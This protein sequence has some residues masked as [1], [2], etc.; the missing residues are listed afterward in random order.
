MKKQ[1]I[2]TAVL[3]F[4]CAMAL[5]LD[6]GDYCMAAV[7]VPQVTGVTAVR[8]DVNSVRV[9]WD[10]VDGAKGYVLY[11]K[12]GSG[13]FQAVK[14]FKKNSCTLR[15]MSV[16]TT[17]CFKVKA[18]AKAGRKTYYGKTSVVRKYTVNDYEYMLDLM[19]PYAHYY[20]YDEYN[21]PTS[22]LHMGG[23]EYR[24]SFKLGSYWNSDIY[25]NAF[26][27]LNGKY[28][29][30]TFYF[31]IKEGSEENDTTTMEVYYDDVLAE[32]IVRNK[33]DIP[34]FVT[35][36]VK[37]VYKLQFEING[38]HDPGFGDVKIYY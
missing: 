31:G 20:R 38:C 15:N 6:S 23:N 5:G 3:L 33:S 30:V 11:M 4:V 27:N 24:H 35:L 29:K 8:T 12:T 19:S 25:T 22:V 26:F 18:Y 32:T 36:D 28:S 7:Y 9:T 16:G 2:K 37:D 1:L 17:Y 34:K 13:K 14:K 21:S 10:A